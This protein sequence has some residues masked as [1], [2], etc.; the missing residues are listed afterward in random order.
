MAEGPACMRPCV[1]SWKVKT[2]W[3]GE[4]GREARMLVE[5]GKGAGMPV[6]AS[7]FVL[8]HDHLRKDTHGVRVFKT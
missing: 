2:K 1:Q 4:R 5:G 6:F 8:L 3:P 7:R